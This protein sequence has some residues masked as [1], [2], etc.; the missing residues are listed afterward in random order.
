MT[1][2]ITEM[3]PRLKAR[4][5]GL[6][7]LIAGQAYSFSEFSVRGKLVVHGDAAATAQNIWHTSRYFD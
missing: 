5:T 3:S 4:V 2:Q 1:E 6:F 7:Y